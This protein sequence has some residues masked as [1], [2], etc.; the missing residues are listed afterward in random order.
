MSIITNT[1]QGIAS[2]RALIHA[3]PRPS[4]SAIRCRMK[5]IIPWPCRLAGKHERTHRPC[6]TKEQLSGCRSSNPPTQQVSEV[7]LSSNNIHLRLVFFLRET[8]LSCIYEGF[9]WFSL[10]RTNDPAL[11][12]LGAVRLFARKCRSRMKLQIPDWLRSDMIV[13]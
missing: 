2:S 7:R 9:G 10:F 13:P 8:R 5:N 1:H 11:S 12:C 4:L 3:H 6:L